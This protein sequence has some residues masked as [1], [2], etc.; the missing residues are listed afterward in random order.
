VQQATPVG[1]LRGALPTAVRFLPHVAAPAVRAGGGRHGG[2]AGPRAW[3]ASASATE[4][5]RLPSRSAGGA[6]RAAGGWYCGGPVAARPAC[7]SAPSWL[8]SESASLASLP[9]MSPTPSQVSTACDSQV[10]TACAGA[11]AGA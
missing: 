8:V 11:A 1:W 5:G 6:G 7:P 3:C 9:A 4:R 10:S 2:G